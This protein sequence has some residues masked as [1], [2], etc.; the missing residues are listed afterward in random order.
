MSNNYFLFSYI[1]VWGVYLSPLVV[2]KG[3]AG[4]IWLI[5]G[6]LKKLS[7]IEFLF[8]WLFSH[9]WTIR[10]VGIQMAICPIQSLWSITAEGIIWWN[11][12]SFDFHCQVENYVYILLHMGQDSKIS[13]IIACLSCQWFLKYGICYL[14]GIKELRVECGKCSY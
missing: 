1:D 13:E 9:L 2:S 11:K 10:L 8:F 3:T 5:L 14:M 12:I 4:R 7:L 6:C